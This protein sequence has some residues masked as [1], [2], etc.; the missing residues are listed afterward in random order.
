[1]AWSYR[2]NDHGGRYDMIWSFFLLCFI[3]LWK[4]KYLLCFKNKIN[5]V[6]P[7]VW[8]LFNVPNVLTCIIE[9]ALKERKVAENE[10]PIVLVIPHFDEY[11]A[12]INRCK[13]TIPSIPDPREHFKVLQGR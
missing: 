7:E 11:Q 5:I 6:G 10:E 12:Y 1:M 3:F 8:E 9:A 4:P 13:A 2:I